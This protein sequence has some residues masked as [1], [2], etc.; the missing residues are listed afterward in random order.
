MKSGCSLHIFTKALNKS[1]LSDMP[2]IHDPNLFFT[3]MNNLWRTK[4]VK[5]EVNFGQK[6]ISSFL[7]QCR[8]LIVF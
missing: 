2:D 6:L 7:R 8:H 5:K 3:L 1:K 4:L